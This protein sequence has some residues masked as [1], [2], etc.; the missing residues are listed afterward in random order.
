MLPPRCVPNRGGVS[1]VLGRGGHPVR[2]RNAEEGGVVGRPS[3]CRDLDDANVVERRLI[4]VEIGIR[5][6]SAERRGAD[7]IG[8]GGVGNVDGVADFLSRAAVVAD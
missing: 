6:V 7:G 2:Q 3:R 5:P 1:T 4:G 8:E